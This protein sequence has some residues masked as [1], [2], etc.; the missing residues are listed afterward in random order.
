YRTEL[1]D[2][3]ENGKV[4]L[5]GYEVASR[6]SY[7]LWNSMP[8]DA[9]LDAA[10]AGE[11]ETLTGVHNWIERMLDDPRAREMT[12][13][14]HNEMLHTEE[15]T[16]ITKDTNRFPEFVP[17]SG[18]Y[19]QTEMEMFIADIIF[20]QDGSYNDLLLT[21]STFVNDNLAAIYGLDGTY[22]ENFVKVELDP[23]QRAGL[24]TRLGFLAKNATAT[25]HDPI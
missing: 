25:Q 12:L 13:A 8:S 18:A 11:L 14:F 17:Q 5:D 16:D 19:M 22:D 3:A 7:S 24:L 9:L 1:S 4:R 20:D 6:L 15:Y 21:P 23:T 2:E 10:E